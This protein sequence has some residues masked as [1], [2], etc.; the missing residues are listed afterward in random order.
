[1]CLVSLSARFVGGVCNPAQG[2]VLNSINVIVNLLP[3]GILVSPDEG[4]VNHCYISLRDKYDL[5]SR[6]PLIINHLF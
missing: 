2:N 4:N 3:G 1:M 5:F 6:S